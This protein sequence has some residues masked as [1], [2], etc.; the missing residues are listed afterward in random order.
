MQASTCTHQRIASVEDTPSHHGVG[1][2]EVRRRLV[3]CDHAAGD[4]E[5]LRQRHADED[6]GQDLRTAAKYISD[7]YACQRF[8]ERRGVGGVEVCSRLVEGDHAAGYGEALRQ[9]HAD[10]DTGEHLHTEASFKR[11]A[12]LSNIQPAPRRWRRRGL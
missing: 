4:G 9:R 5:A 11:N 6:A 3:E 1:A 2:V 10:E 8:G 7:R 12:R